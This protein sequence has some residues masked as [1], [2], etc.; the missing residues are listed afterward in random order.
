MARFLT[1]KAMVTLYSGKRRHEF[2]P[3]LGQVG[4]CLELLES[5]LRQK[6]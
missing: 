6:C 3:D 1:A 4:R 2:G 5:L